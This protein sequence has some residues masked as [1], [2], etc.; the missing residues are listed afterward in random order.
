MFEGESILV[1]ETVSVSADGF[2]NRKTLIHSR[3]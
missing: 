1:A 3:E 2:G